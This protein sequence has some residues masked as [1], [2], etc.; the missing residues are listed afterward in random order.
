[1]KGCEGSLSMI[2]AFGQIWPPC[3]IPTVR[4]SCSAPM[5]HRCLRIAEITDHIVSYIDVDLIKV[6]LVS[7]AF[8]S[9]AMNKI[10]RELKGIE[11][12][13]RLL[14]GHL[15]QDDSGVLVSTFDD[16]SY[17]LRDRNSGSISMESLMGMT[18]R[19]STITVPEF[20]HSLPH[21]CPTKT[22]HTAILTSPRMTSYESATRLHLF[23][24]TSEN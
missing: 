10:W 3:R 6:S 12:L 21:G 4:L 23:C 8:Y 22:R 2:E 11:P 7:H 14:P 15:L 18:G 9:P 20:G 5:M 16:Y 24:P 13:V 1:M 17:L 19:A